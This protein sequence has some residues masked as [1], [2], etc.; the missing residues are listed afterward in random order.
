MAVADQVVA[1]GLHV[2]LFGMAASGK[3][4][5]LGALVQAAQGQPQLLGGRLEEVPMG[6]QKLRQNVYENKTRETREEIVPYPLIFQGPAGTTPVTFFDCDGRI[7]EDYLLGKKGLDG[8]GPDAALAQAIE[9]ADTLIFAV[10]AATPPAKLEQ[11]FAQFGA[12]LRLFEELRG[13]ENEAAG[14]PVYLVLT[15]CDLL[16]RPEDTASKWMQ[17]IEEG[18]RK[19]DLK[20]R[21]FL[22]RQQQEG[23]GLFG[24]VDLHLWAT[25]VKRPTL[26]DRPAKAAEPFGVA[27]LFRQALDS[28]LAFQRYRVQTGRRLVLA[29][30]GIVVLVAFLGILAALFYTNRPSADVAALEQR[31]KQALPADHNDRLREPVS[32][33]LMQLKEI[34]YDPAFTKLPQPMQDDVKAAVSELEAY[35]SWSNE[36]KSKA[37]D[38]RHITR[39]QELI[40]SEKLLEALA[41]PAAYARDWSETKFAQRR[42]SW[43]SDFKKLRA[44]LDAEIAWIGD[45]IKESD[46]LR[47][48]GGLVIAQT[49]TP[50]ERDQWLTKIRQFLERDLRHK[51]TERIP[52]SNLVY[53]NVYR[54]DRLQ[55][56]RGDWEKAKRTLEKVR[57]QAQ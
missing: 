43:L 38:P 2:V 5:L 1:E 19:I 47:K 15:K 25:A 31:V 16:A 9:Q 57:E 28:G 42:L 12:F 44:A 26:S 29:A 17:R 33:R 55:Q 36:F 53:K 56:A 4:S 37:Q 18:K 49:V 20:F 8:A 35:V 48:K 23:A 14:L 54:F 45:Q 34:G 21:E 13:Q 7:A 30:A 39:A 27:E 46:E 32:E 41:P 3:S 50:Q 24:T 10:D 40:K 51:R 22:A 52:G 11:D 6:L